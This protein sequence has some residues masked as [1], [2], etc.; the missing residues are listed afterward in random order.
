MRTYKYMELCIKHKYLHVIWTSVEFT[1]F[2]KPSF[3]TPPVPLGSACNMAA[4]RGHINRANYLNLFLVEVKKQ[5]WREMQVEFW[6]PVRAEGWE[7][8]PFSLSSEQLKRREGYSVD[9]TWGNGLRGFSAFLVWCQTSPQGDQGHLLQKPDSR[10]LGVKAVHFGQ[11][12]QIKRLIMLKAGR[13]FP[14][15]GWT[16]NS[17]WTHKNTLVERMD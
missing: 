7:D 8:P 2:D 13:I 3:K 14:N 4:L 9:K 10:E 6:K 16:C 12:S 11:F 17:V 5:P 15:R 1:M